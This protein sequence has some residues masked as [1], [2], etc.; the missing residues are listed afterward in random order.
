[1]KARH[2]AVGAGNVFAI[3]TD[4]RIHYI[5]RGGEGLWGGWQTTAATA[6]R[7]AHG[8]NVVGLIGLDGQVAALQ[9]GPGM[10][11]SSWDLQANEISATSVPDVGP[12]LF[13]RGDDGKVWHTWKIGPQWAQWEC[14]EGSVQQIDSTVIPGGGLVVFGIH[15]GAVTHRWQDKPFTPWRPWTSLDA[16][17]GGATG[18]CVAT[19]THG[20]LALFA[21][22]SDGRIYHRWQD[23]PFGS[24]HPWQLIGNGV[25]S[26]MV[27]KT[28][29]EGLALFGIGTQ[30]EVRSSHQLK[31]FGPWTAWTDLGGTA[32][33]VAGHASYSDGLEVFII[34]RDEEV[35]HRW[36]DRLD[37]EWTV[38][39]PLE[40]ETS[41]LRV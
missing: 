4:D 8:G 20:G 12:A 21:S 31:P 30:G 9:P 7:L 36:C 38:W 32:V 18:L 23:K 14:L 37:W 33:E 29:S 24:W 34:G 1:M 35:G 3:G 19:I 39:V 6:Q 26:L 2:I 10:T 25:H 11:S 15:D 17:P 28:P 16:P 13:A 40:H 41:P 5:E 22:T 27:T